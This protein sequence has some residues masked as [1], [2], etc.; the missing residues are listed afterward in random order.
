MPFCCIYQSV[1]VQD[2]SQNHSIIKHVRNVTYELRR[3]GDF[4]I[5]NKELITKAVNYAKKNAT[6]IDLTVKDITENAGFS[7]DYFNR[8]FLAHT[9]FTVMAYVN[10]MRL[11]KAVVLL[12]NT[13]MSLLDITLEVGYESH[14]GFIKAFKKKY[15]ITPSEYRAN[16]SKTVLS[17]GELTDKS[18]AARFIHTNPDFSLVD[19]HCVIDTLL[20]KDAKRY[21][22]LCT[23]IKYMGLKIAAPGGN[24]ENGFIGI[25]DDLNGNI[26]LELVT[27]SFEQLANW[28]DRFPDSDSFYSTCAPA[29]IESRLAELGVDCDIAATPQSM[30]FEDPLKYDLPSNISIRQLT[31]SDKNSI[32]KWANGRKNGYIDHLLNEKHYLDDTVL[33]YGVFEEGELIAIA[34]CGIDEVHGLKLNNC[35]QIRFADGKSNDVLY[36]PIYAYIVNDILNKGVLPFDDLQHGE[37]AKQNGNF[38]STDLG[39]EVVNWKYNLKNRL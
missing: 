5:E 13:E 15:C 22:Y 12:R 7:I 34:E 30:Y 19:T 27:D 8:L 23:T 35:C 29:E 28:L 4:I 31:C 6:S 18:V 11:K 21:S 32:I 3:K 24:I 1:F 39:F 33:E 16:N 25:G 36:R 37:Y 26:Y 17:F 9:G 38:T 10:Y 20:E 14:E 2:K